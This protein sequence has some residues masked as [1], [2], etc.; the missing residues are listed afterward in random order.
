VEKAIVALLFFQLKSCGLACNLSR[1]LLVLTIVP[2]LASLCAIELGRNV[3][4]KGTCC[5]NKGRLED[6]RL[7]L[8]VDVGVDV[9]RG[10]IR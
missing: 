1:G 10:R 8:G 5:G 2:Q 9:V 4:V 3:A 7:A 6:I